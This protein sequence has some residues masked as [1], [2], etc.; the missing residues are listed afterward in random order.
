MTII[1]RVRFIVEITESL[2]LY[3]ALCISYFGTA[4]V[5]LDFGNSPC[6]LRCYKCTIPVKKDMQALD[7][8]A[9]GTCRNLKPETTTEFLSFVTIRPIP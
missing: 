4:F 6:S 7:G 5:V 2:G 8:K 3:A 9:Q 1:G